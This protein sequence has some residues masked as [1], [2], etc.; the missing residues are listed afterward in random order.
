MSTMTT[1][2]GAGGAGGAKIAKLTDLP[3]P[4]ARR[5]G[6][7]WTEIATLPEDYEDVEWPTVSAICPSYN[8]G[9]FFEEALRSLLLQRYPKL[10]IVVMDG[11]SNDETL[12]IADKYRD[13]IDIFV[14]ESDN[15]P[16]H[17]VNKALRASKGNII[18]WLNT[19]D[20]QEPGA[21][22]TATRIF[23]KD[24][25]VRW[26]SGACEHYWDGEQAGEM[27]QSIGDAHRAEWLFNCQVQTPATFWDRAL[28]DEVGF[29]DEDFFYM[30][31]TDLFYRFVLGGIEPRILPEKLASFRLHSASKCGVETDR[32]RR[33][34]VE[35][36]MPRYFAGLPP[37]EQRLA[38]EIGAIKLLRIAEL[39]LKNRKL[40]GSVQH[41]LRAMS[42]SPRAV[43][44]ALARRAKHD[45][46]PIL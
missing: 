25:A 7:P 15:G 5:T 4:P 9:R 33:E 29:F 8:Q 18:C 43:V 24:N 16:S 21:M 35:K 37:E 38:K 41:A 2:G 17:A 44:R 3:E 46:A 20:R 12:E 27:R 26:V 19:D 22:F 23:A 39:E 36:M 1:G 30:W 6:W 10:E 13:F 34:A 42:W 32:F 14:S 40:G 11:G 28:H 31:D 45:P